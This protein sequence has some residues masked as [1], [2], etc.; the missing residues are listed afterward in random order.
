MEGQAKVRSQWN[1]DNAA[2]QQ[3]SA[4]LDQTSAWIKYLRGQQ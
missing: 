3:L 2:H 4:L 1:A